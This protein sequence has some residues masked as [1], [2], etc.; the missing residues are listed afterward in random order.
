[1]T[2][3]KDAVASGLFLR[4][5]TINVHKI[6]KK[7]IIFLF[8]LFVNLPIWSSE[9]V[10]IIISDGI[11][12]SVLKEKMEQAMSAVFT[13]VAA[14][15]E[16]NRSPRYEVMGITEDAKS[17]ISGLWENSPFITEGSQQ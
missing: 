17:D 11:E 7:F 10:S 8:S 2:I 3:I 15:H 6:M 13:E 4:N 14:A 12:N 16:A 5:N 1:M 9:P